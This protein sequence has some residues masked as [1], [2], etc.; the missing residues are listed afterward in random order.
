MFVKWSDDRMLPITACEGGPHADEFKPSIKPATIV[1]SRVRFR[2]YVGE[3]RVVRRLY[4]E[5]DRTEPPRWYVKPEDSDIPYEPIPPRVARLWA[6]TNTGVRYS[7]TCA[8]TGPCARTTRAP[9]RVTCGKD[10]GV[11]S[12]AKKPPRE[13]PQFAPWSNVG[14]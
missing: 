11:G 8:G 12:C 10:S 4:L 3:S 7:A 5:F 13:N 2:T 1:E 9:S 14:E 6:T